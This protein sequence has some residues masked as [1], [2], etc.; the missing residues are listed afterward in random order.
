MEQKVEVKFLGE[1][2]FQVKAITSGVSLCVDKSAPDY[3]SQGP[4][5]L[6]V[7]LSALG[8]CTGVF[9][10]KYLSRHNI[11]FKELRVEAKAEFTTTP[12][13]RLTNIGVKVST[14]AD[15][16][17]NREVFLRFM[18]N[19]PVHNTILGTDQINIELT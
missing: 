15:L 2:K 11:D 7:F 19:C 10:K 14:D 12:P 18:K 4:N 8:S 6:E 3:K 16:G 9:A 17:L 13:A 1:D 5:P